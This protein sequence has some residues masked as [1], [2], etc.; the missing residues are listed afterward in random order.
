MTNAAPRASAVN[1]CLTHDPALAG[2]YRAINDFAAALDAPILSFDD[3]RRDRRSL[4][5]TEPCSVTR[6]PAGTGWL[7]RD[8]HVVTQAAAAQA[9]AALA[10]AGLLV[11]HSLFR[12]HATWAAGLAQRRKVRL[13]AVP[14]GCLDPWGLSQR[15]WLKR[16]W[17]AVY[18][19]SYFSQAERVVFATRREA[20]KAARWIPAGRGT[21]VHWPVQLPE[22]GDREFRRQQ[23]RDRLGI[24]DSERLLL[25]VGRLHSMKRPIETVRAFCAAGASNCHLVIVGM[26]GDITA[27][28]VQAS[29]PA[30]Y[31]QRVHVIGPLTGA[32]LAAAYFAADG[33]ISLSFRENFGYAAAEAIAHGLPVI[34]SPGHDLACELPSRGGR[35]ACGWLLPDDSPSSAEQAI[36]GFCRLS[37]T[38]VETIR[39]AG[40]AWAR[41]N[42]SVERFSD[43]LRSLVD[44]GTDV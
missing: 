40:S 4:A 2:L 30:A 12:G 35:L 43:T 32:D 3:G 15:R 26:D 25:S 1:V 27:A 21:V 31:Q 6:I 28:Q 10:D 13:W 38:E 19:P 23:F 20:E 14:H 22:F 7:S 36:G 9:E 42:L 17:L 24:D 41:D 33:F 16:A 29:V 11:V 5:A 37:A 18:G 39:E 34:L 44:R 8:C